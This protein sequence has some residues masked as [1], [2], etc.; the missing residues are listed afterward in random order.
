M[1]MT[2]RTF[3]LSLAA[4]AAIGCTPPQTAIEVDYVFEN[5]NVVPLSV[6][7]VLAN[8]AVAVRNGEIVAIVDQSLADNIE[9]STRI[10]AAGKY[11]MP[12]LA[13]MHVHI[14]M[15]P[16]AAFNL[17][18]ATGLVDVRFTPESGH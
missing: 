3:G 4:S 11:L 16:K 18:L 17:F 10:D 14:R 13:D 6:E 9:A 15:N 12:G 1:Q 5:V 7:V 2:L 8:K